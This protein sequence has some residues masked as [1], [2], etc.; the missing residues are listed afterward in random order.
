MRGSNTGNRV[1][2][3]Y[4]AYLIVLTERAMGQKPKAQ[5]NA[6]IARPGYKTCKPIVVL[7]E[8]AIKLYTLTLT[9][10]M[11]HSHTGLFKRIHEE[12]LATLF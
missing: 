1:R 10:Q 3:L 12:P 2:R 8:N 5:R 11:C 6:R 9:L 7:G 4:L